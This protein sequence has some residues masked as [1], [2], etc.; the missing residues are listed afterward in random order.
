MG[1]L[2]KLEITVEDTAT[3]L[4][5]NSFRVPYQ[6][7]ALL[8]SENKTQEVARLVRVPFRQCFAVLQ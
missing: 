3:P 5:S 1:S 4:T 2:Y 6:E 8:H 7:A